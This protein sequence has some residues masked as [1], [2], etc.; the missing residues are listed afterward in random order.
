M[1]AK[2]LYICTLYEGVA[3]WAE[4][5][6]IFIVAMS[7]MNVI[8]IIQNQ[9]FTLDQVRDIVLLSSDVIVQGER[10][11]FVSSSRPFDIFY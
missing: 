6:Q 8:A 10:N 1:S 9:D 11:E 2:N 3:N 5:D 4:D 7:F